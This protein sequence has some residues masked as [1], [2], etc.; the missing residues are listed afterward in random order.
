M[1][2]TLQPRRIFVTAT[3]TGIGKTYT[4]LQ[5]MEQIAAAGLRVG[6]LK[7]IET[8]VQDL[9]EDGAL[10]HEALLRLN[11]SAAGATVDDV[12]PL[13]FALPA[14]PL[15]AKEKA[16]IDYHAIDKALEKMEAVCD[17]CL[18]EGAGGLMVPVDE[19]IAMI[20]LIIRFE[21]QALLVAHCKLGCINDTLLSLE[22]LRQRKIPHLFALNC[23]GEE[24]FDA[25]SRPYFDRFFQPWYSLDDPKTLVEILLKRLH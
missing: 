16:L 23:R 6:V 12:V 24:D 5:L 15:I 21:A 14:A 9:P 17:V 1:R 25:I 19:Y 22:A 8:G 20:D 4:T 11:P 7:P 13:Q 2:R 3:N 18:I 10:L